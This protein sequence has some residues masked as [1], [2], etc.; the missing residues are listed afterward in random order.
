M[1]IP[2]GKPVPSL[3]LGPFCFECYYP[4][5]IY[6]LFEDHCI[7]ANNQ[8]FELWL[9][10]KNIFLTM[11]DKIIHNETTKNIFIDYY[12]TNP[13]NE[14]YLYRIKKLLSLT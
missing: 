12:F 11:N 7:C 8:H 10:N 13:Q 5:S 9:E 6:T 2:V 14:N 3:N 1:I 4:V